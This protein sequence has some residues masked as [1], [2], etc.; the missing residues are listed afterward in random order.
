MEMDVLKEKD[1]RMSTLKKLV[2]PIVQDNNVL[3][4]NHYVLI[5]PVILLLIL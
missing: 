5:K 4:I 2:K 1:V 3:G